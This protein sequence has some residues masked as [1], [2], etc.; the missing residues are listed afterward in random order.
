M[1]KKFRSTYYIVFFNSRNYWN[2][3]NIQHFNFFWNFQEK[4]SLIKRSII[5]LSLDSISSIIETYSLLM[6]GRFTWLLLSYQ[7]DGDI[8]FMMVLMSNINVFGTNVSAFLKI[9]FVIWWSSFY[10]T[11][12]T[13]WNLSRHFK[14]YFKNSSLHWERSCLNLTY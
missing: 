5:V 1:V 3:Q 2:S 12:F 6:N 11:C 4:I 9:S 7:T 13:F 8:I 14:Q 10:V